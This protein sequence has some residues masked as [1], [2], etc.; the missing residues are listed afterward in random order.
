VALEVVAHH[1]MNGITWLQWR[2]G[3]Q[4]GHVGGMWQTPP[5]QSAPVLT[6][7]RRRLC[8]SS[9]VCL[10]EFDTVGELQSKTYWQEAK[11]A[12]T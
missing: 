11:G 6:L 9:I 2:L 10:R 4:H 3:L 1:V 8:M 12:M 7:R 5:W